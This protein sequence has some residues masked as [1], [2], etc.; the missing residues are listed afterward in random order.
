MANATT[1]SDTPPYVST[2]Q[3]S[4]TVTMAWR[5]PRRRSIHCAMAV[6]APESAISCPNSAP[7]KNTGKYETT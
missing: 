5:G 4:T 6:A 7:S 2:A 1:N 3:A